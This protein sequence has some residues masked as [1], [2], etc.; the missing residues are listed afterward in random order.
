MA[1]KLFPSH[2]MYTLLPLMLTSDVN[3]CAYGV[4][5]LHPGSSMNVAF[6]P[7]T[8]QFLKRTM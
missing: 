1:V 3:S 7:W 8:F 5:L 2:A 6:C 4:A